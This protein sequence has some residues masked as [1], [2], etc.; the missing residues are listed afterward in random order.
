MCPKQKTNT[1]MCF[2][3]GWNLGFVIEALSHHMCRNQQTSPGIG[4]VSASM[5]FG[6]AVEIGTGQRTWQQ[7]EL[8][9]VVSFA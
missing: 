6:I 8:C 3:C 5:A 4:Y 1:H 2:P 9:E 7:N